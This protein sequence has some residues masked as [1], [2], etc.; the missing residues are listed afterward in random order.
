MLPFRAPRGLSF[1][2]VKV[3]ASFQSCIRLALGQLLEYAYWS[4]TDRAVELVVV[5]EHH[6]GDDGTMYLGA[7]RDRF[8]LPICYRQVDLE[9]GT[10][11]PRV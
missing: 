7:L 5:G 3:A 11:G 6:P 1:Y 4:S 9:A 10:I 2:E 8:H